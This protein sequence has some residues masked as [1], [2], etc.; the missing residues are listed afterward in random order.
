MLTLLLTISYIFRVYFFRNYVLAILFFIS[1][2]IILIA[3][4][5]TS[6]VVSQYPNLFFTQFIMGPFFGPTIYLYTLSV[7]KN[8][9][10]LKKWEWLYFTPIIIMC[11]LI[12]PYYFKSNVEKTAIIIETFKYTSFFFNTIGLILSFYTL[13]FIILSIYQFVKNVRIENPTHKRISMLFISIFLLMNNGALR[14][15]CIFLGFTKYIKLANFIISLNVFILYIIIQRFPYLVQYGSLKKEKEI[16]S[17]SYLNNVNLN[18][19][20]KQLEFLMEVEKYYLDENLTLT[21]LSEAL[22]ISPHQLSELLNEHFKKN[23]NSF[24]NSFRIKES[25]KLLVNEPEENTLHI[26]LNVGFNS[27]TSFYSSFKKE[28]GCSP[29]FFRRNNLLEVDMK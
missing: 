22:E 9:R 28:T 17:Q 4:L 23:F 29:T 13:I 6:G 3:H 1:G 15:M 26:A 18:H 12:A 7:T 11:F 14:L 19:I 21:K 16:K 25:K 5:F 27:Y 8:K 10:Y 24:V 20:I 2:N